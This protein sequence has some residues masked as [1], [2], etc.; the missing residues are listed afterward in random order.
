MSWQSSSR[1]PVLA[2]VLSAIACLA[3]LAIDAE[4]AY[5]V[6]ASTTSTEESGLFGHIL[7]V[8][9]K[10]A[11]IDVRVVAVGTGQAI[12]LAKR[13][14]A[15]VLFVHHKP[16]EQQFVA[17]GYGAKR[18]PVMWNDFI[19]VGPKFDPAGIGGRRTPCKHL[20]RSRGRKHCS[21]RGATIAA[22]IKRN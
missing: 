22:R 15:D 6:V 3:S 19:I 11:G 12:E 14:D 2:L 10:Q 16:S 4:A 21:P 8:F 20:P 1:A 17:E 18:Y 7:P 5:I 9:E 13:G